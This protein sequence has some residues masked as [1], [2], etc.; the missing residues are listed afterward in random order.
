MS[1]R[2]Y[3]KSKVDEFNRDCQGATPEDFDELLFTLL[4]TV[5]QERSKVLTES[6]NKFLN[7]NG[8]GL[9]YRNRD[10]LAAAVGRKALPIHAP[11]WDEMIPQCVEYCKALQEAGAYDNVDLIDY[12]AL[13]QEAYHRYFW[14]KN[15]AEPDPKLKDR[16]RNTINGWVGAV[17]LVVEIMQKGILPIKEKL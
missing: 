10:E 1:D 15:C 11:K 14:Q 6:I 16:D 3:F 17:A 5:A 12:E 4:R 9:C 13:A 7:S 2:E 8:H